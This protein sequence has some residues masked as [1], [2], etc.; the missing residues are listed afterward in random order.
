[1]A[2]RR[3]RTSAKQIERARLLIDGV[4]A[5]AEIQAAVTPFGYSVRR[6]QEGK[7]LLDTV[8]A[9]RNTSERRHSNKVAASAGT[10]SATDA[11]TKALSVP[12]K[13]ARAVLS[14]QEAAY[15]ALG[16]DRGPLPRSRA[17][18]L[19]AGR[20]FLNALDTDPA[21]AARLE[22]SGLT[23]AR[24]AAAKAALDT[25]AQAQVAGAGTQGDAENATPEAQAALDALNAWT[26]QLR[27][28]ARIA[29]AEHPQHLEKLGIK[30]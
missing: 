15:G 30:A 10:Q 13:I 19:D 26:M 14:S 1:M 25:L 4:L 29:L 5:D 21:L 11:A 16:L 18:L 27:K 22:S 9:K 8:L 12:V 7:S 20:R 28:L 6:M 24:R 2:T 23:L 17:A 3:S